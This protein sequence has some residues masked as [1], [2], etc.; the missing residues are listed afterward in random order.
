MSWNIPNRQEAYYEVQS[1]LFQSALVDLVLA[2]NGTGVRTGC[3]V[4]VSSGMTVSVSSGT[5]QFNGS[6][7]VNIAGGNLS[8]SANSDASSGRIDIIQASNLGVISVVSG[9]LSVEPVEPNLSGTAVKL[10]AIYLPPSTS[11]VT[12]AMI[13]DRRV[14]VVAPYSVYEYAVNTG[15]Y[16]GT[17]ANFLDS[18]Q[19][20]TGPAGPAGENVRFLDPGESIAG[21]P[22]GTKICRR[23]S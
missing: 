6:A 5:V 11:A 12:T 13:S 21:L 18:L 19:G 8:L 3:S 14:E 1:R 7:P 20:A 9:A 17:E 2:R 16:A 15:Q 4:T 22:N 10:A 23:Y